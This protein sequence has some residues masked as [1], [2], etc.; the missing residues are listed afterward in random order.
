VSTPTTATVD[1]EDDR[2]SKTQLKQQSHDL[3][4]LGQQLADLPA[5]PARHAE[6]PESL[7]DALELYR[8]TKSHEGRRRQMQ[9]V[10]KLMRSVDVEPLRE[11][12]AAAEL[13]T[14]QQALQLHEMERWR[15]EL[16]ADDEAL[17]RWMQRP[18]RHRRA[19][20]AQPGAR[21]APRHRHAGPR[22]PPAALRARAVPVHQAPPAGQTEHHERTST[23]SASAWSRSATA[24]PAAS[25]R[26]R[27]S[28][29]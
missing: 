2:P 11:A 27:A 3:Q 13:G 29:R 26:T 22:R 6:M 21:R 16:I 23:R 5:G 28:R 7:R 12:V 4:K 8:R 19:A 20:A 9:Y 15:A 14:A 1:E 25:T 18:P 10:G 24:R 17:T